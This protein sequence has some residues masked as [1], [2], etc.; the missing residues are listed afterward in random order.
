M[1]LLTKHYS[2]NILFGVKKDHCLGK[3]D[4]LFGLK[5]NNAVVRKWEPNSSPM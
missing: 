2:K 3:N 4:Y 1:S 5:S